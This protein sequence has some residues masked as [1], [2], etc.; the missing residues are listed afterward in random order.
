MKK[1]IY[2]LFFVL[3]IHLTSN[4][5]NCSAQWMQTNGPGGGTV[6]SLAYNGSN[7]FAGTPYGVFISTNNGTTWILTALNNY[8]QSL[9]VSGNNIF[10]GTSPNGVFL[11]TNNGTN[12][13][14][15]SLN[16]KS[17]SSLATSGNYIFAGAYLGSIYD[18]GVYCST[19]NG[20]NWTHTS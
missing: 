17:I 9:A 11:S 2:S 15:T 7:I 8:V 19:N 16:N 10:A 20:T 5:E 18:S 13:A 12:W 3:I 6:N 1:L 4:I 14:Q